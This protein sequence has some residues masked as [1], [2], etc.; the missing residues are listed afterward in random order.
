[1]ARCTR[2]HDLRQLRGNRQQVVLGYCFSPFGIA[3][4]LRVTEAR[5]DTCGLLLTAAEFLICS[6][7]LL[8]RLRHCYAGCARPQRCDAGE[9]AVREAGGFVDEAERRVP[10]EI[11]VDRGKVRKGRR[12]GEELE[13]QPMTGVIGIEQIAR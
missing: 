1:M 3:R 2:A 10:V 4:G 13:G 6:F 9:H 12:L 7:W 11:P 5:S 8:A